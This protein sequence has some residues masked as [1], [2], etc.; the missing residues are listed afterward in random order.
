[1][2]ENL[3]EAVRNEK[4][5]YDVKHPHYVKIKYKNSIWNRIGSDLS[6]RD[7]ELSLYYNL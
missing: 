1:M 3:I 6:F 7:G 2:E 5:L 4:C